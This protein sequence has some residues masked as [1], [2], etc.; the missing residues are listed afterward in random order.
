MLF[1]FTCH[2]A[3]HSVLTSTYDLASDAKSFVVSYQEA[4]TVERRGW[5]FSVNQQQKTKRLELPGGAIYTGT[6]KGEWTGQL[7]YTRNKKS[8]VRWSAC[9]LIFYSINHCSP[10]TVNLCKSC[11]CL[12]PINEGVGNTKPLI[13]LKR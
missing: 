11:M 12:S 2:A 9:V 10:L 7:V 13:L 1:Q 5:L 4:L 3:S 8:T 6:Y